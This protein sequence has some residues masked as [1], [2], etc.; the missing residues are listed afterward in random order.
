[1]KKSIKKEF[2]CRF[3]EIKNIDLSTNAFIHGDLFPDNA[4]FLDDK[5]TGVYDFTHS[6]YGNKNFDLAVLI[7]SW[8][9]ENFRF[10][11]EYFERILKLYDKQLSVQK[12]KPYLL[13]AAL[14]YALQRF[15][16]KHTKQLHSEMLKKFDI[17]KKIL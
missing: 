8:C 10:N 9:F 17:L 4:K 15:T 2:L 12:I 7:I 14:Y 5:L 6:C 16:R 1:M 3:E 11:L 13:Y